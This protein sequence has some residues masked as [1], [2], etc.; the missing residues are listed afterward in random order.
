MTVSLV[1]VTHLSAARLRACLGSL[2]GVDEVVVVDHSEDAEEQRRLERLP[3]DRLV[4]QPNAGYAAGLNRGAREASGDLLL[5]A[6]PD[7]EL[8]PGAAATLARAAAEPGVGVAAPALVWDRDGRWR[9]PHATRHTWRSELAGRWTPRSAARA[10]HRRQLRLWRARR[11]VSTEVVSGTLMATTRAVFESTGG[12]DEGFF[13]FFEENDWCRRLRRAG[14]GVVVVPGARVVHEVGHAVGAAESEHYP[15]SLA[16][17]RRLHFPSWYLRLAPAPLPPAQPRWPLAA[18]PPAPGAELLLSPSPG[19][20]PAVLTRWEG[21]AWHRESL[22]P[23]AA[24][25]PECHAAAVE[26]E[27]VRALGRVPG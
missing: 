12:L 20:V 11:T 10:W 16:R 5:L 13:L 22:L 21:G 17:F 9:I 18:A 23:P 6:N 19:L 26:G 2:E 14:L 7:L 24:R 1:V 15:R 8:L 4:V 3:I 25:W 27:R